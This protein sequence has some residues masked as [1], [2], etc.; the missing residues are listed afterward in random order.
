[1]EQ[2]KEIS[3]RAVNATVHL[4]FDNLSFLHLLF[5]FDRD[6][7]LNRRQRFNGNICNLRKRRERDSGTRGERLFESINLR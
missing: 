4:V 7:F 6:L 1:M 2:F 3:R 5:L